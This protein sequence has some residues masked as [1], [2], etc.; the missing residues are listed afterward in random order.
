MAYL[1]TFQRNQQ[2]LLGR[3]RYDKQHSLF[4]QS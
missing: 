3:P 1:N 2:R 4:H